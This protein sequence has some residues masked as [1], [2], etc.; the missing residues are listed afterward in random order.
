[1]SDPRNARPGTGPRPAAAVG[2]DLLADSGAGAGFEA[3]LAATALDGIG[4]LL[5]PAELRRAAWA[6]LRHPKPVARQLTHLAARLGGIG[7]GT[8]EQP[9]RLDRRFADPAWAEN[10]ILSRLA[11]GYLAS[12]D[13]ALTLLG[14]LDLD[15]RTRERLRLILDNVLAADS[16]TNNP[17]LNPAAWKRVI[18][19]GGISAAR[20]LRNL[21]HDM[22]SPTKLPST[23]DKS[24]FILGETIAA[25][26]GKVVRV[27]D[28][29]ELIEYEP[30]TETVDAV[31]VLMIASPVN[32]YYLVDLSPKTSLIR[33]EL[34]R[35][36]RVFVASWVNPDERHADAGCDAYVSSIVDML[37]TVTEITGS[38]QAHL[39]GLC[40]GGQLAVMAA[41]YLAAIGRQHQLATLTIGIAVI[42]FD[43]GPSTMA[44]LDRKTADKAIADAAKRGFFNAS[45]SA[46]SF[47]LIRPNDGIWAG[48]VNNY[49]LGNQPP[50]LDLLFWAADQTNVTARFGR[51]MIEVA[52]GNQLATPGGTTVL[53]VPLDLRKITVDTYVLGG[54]TDHISPWLDCFRTLALL[55]GTTTFVLARGGHAVVVARPPGSPRAS[56]RTGDVT[57]T[58]PNEWLATS[59]DNTGSW[60]EHWNTWIG[61]HTPATTPAPTR[62]GSDAYPPV[63]DAPG[64]NIHRRLT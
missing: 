40:G 2:D 19:T 21:A 56:Y 52:L 11:L 41:A 34:E 14:E 49:L 28:L 31:P 18:D 42:G 53:G 16:P 7:R 58:D 27:G 6:M 46:R 48:V 47:A 4:G 32:K 15:W 43:P 26:P 54:S 44:F 1:M 64:E 37:D 45:E 20:G 38:D 3:V 5:P 60:W 17:L 23:V 59:T 63:R 25:T 35:G 51:D 62:I 61:K 22:R 55:G 12:C 9:G 36:R 33:A 8:K 10:P 50:A 24:G 39:L 29:F 13:A 57:G 30:L